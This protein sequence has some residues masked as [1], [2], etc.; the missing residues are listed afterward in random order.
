MRLAGNF[1]TTPPARNRLSR[2][3]PVGWIAAHAGAKVKAD[4]SL[5]SNRFIN[6]QDWNFKGT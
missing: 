6:T 5:A 1:Y 4:V 3:D 2:L